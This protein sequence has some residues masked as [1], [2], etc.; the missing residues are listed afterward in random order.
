MDKL[1]VK[2]FFAPENNTT[3]TLTQT[4]VLAGEDLPAA[5][6]NGKS[7]PFCVVCL[8]D[9]QKKKA[10]VEQRTP[11]IKETLNPDWGDTS[12]FTL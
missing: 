11:I 7:D 2:G 4:S 5:D 9:E 10:S 8:Y 12:E 6:R 1:T 3:L